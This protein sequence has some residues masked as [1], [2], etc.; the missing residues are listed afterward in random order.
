MVMELGHLERALQ[1]RFKEEFVDSPKSGPV[2]K[3]LQYAE[4]N[5][6]EDPKEIIKILERKGIDYKESFLGKLLIR[7]VK[8]YEQKR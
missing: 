5:N 3:V 8:A 2:F 6:I 7:R 1:K 4:E